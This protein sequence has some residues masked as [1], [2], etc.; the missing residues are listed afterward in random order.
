MKKI[1]FIFT[2]LAVISIIVIT[3]CQK[4][5]VGNTSNAQLTQSERIENL[6]LNFKHKLEN[7]LKDGTVYSAD[8]A[9]WYVEALLNYTYGYATALG[10]TFETDS[11]AITVNNTGANGYNLQQLAG[12]YNYFEEK[13]VNNK[14]EDRYIFAIDISLATNGSQTVF[15]SITGYAKQL[16]PNLKSTADTSGYWFW[17]NGLGMCGPDSGLYVGM[18]A[19]DIIEALVNEIAEYDYFTNIEHHTFSFNNY[20]YSNF[21]FTDQY[22]I[23]S[24]LFAYCDPTG[25]NED[26]CLSPSHI[27]FY[28]G[29]DGAIYIVKDNKPSNREFA[30]C[31]ITPLTYPSDDIDN[32]II[33]IYYGSPIERP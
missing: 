1:L 19:G 11:V 8:S 20:P 26:F 10:C 4:E 14:P 15:S 33:K 13:V 5:D 32:H 7:N 18:D 3:A 27:A 12:V 29:D 30:Y 31:T 23:H 22:L 25:P 28:S 9:V 24:R 17:G 2:A 16:L 6:I 21:P